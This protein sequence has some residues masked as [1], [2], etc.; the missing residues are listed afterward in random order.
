MVFAVAVAVAA[1][2]QET[3]GEGNDPLN[4]V[5]KRNL[6]PADRSEDLRLK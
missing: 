4:A 2:A 6:I 5:V 3:P 1:Y